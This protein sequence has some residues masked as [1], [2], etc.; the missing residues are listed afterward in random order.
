MKRVKR[1]KKWTLLLLGL[2]LLSQSPFVYRRF[3]LRALRAKIHELNSSRT[4]SQDDPYADYKGVVHVHSSLG[5]HSTGGF[6]EIVEAARRNG[7]GFVVMTEHPSATIDTAEMTLKGTQGGVLFINGNEASTAAG[8]RFLVLPGS[9][10]ARSA[11]TRATQDFI[12]EEKLDGRLTF[13]AYP[14]E[15]RSWEAAEGYNGIEV[16]N[17]YT[18]ARR[19]NPLLMFFDGLWSYGSYPD[20]LF[21]RFYERPTESLKRWDDLNSAKARRLVALAGNDAH[22][23]VGIQLGDAGGKKYLGILLDPYSRSFQIV[24]THA[25]VEKER[26]LTTEA[27]LEALAAGHCYIAFDLLADATGFRFYARSANATAIMGDSLPLSEGDTRLNVSTPIKS[28]IVLFRNGRDVEESPETLSKV[29]TVKER[30]VYR[31]EVYLDAL[32]PTFRDR[33]W[34]ISNPIYIE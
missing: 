8:D 31:V 18:N 22:Q 5:G 29:F 15:F 33:P 12:T 28:R 25:L 11:G 6:T 21:T 2:L 9:S 7:L 20:L 34:I 4:V 23:N 1:W 14:Q 30:G 26:V 13:L 3:Q 17:L 19:I 27:L 32:G 16:Y 10:R 24:R